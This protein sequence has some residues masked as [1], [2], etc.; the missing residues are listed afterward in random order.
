M[1]PISRRQAL[2]L[3]LVGAASVA[4]GANGLAR[5][6]SADS[7][8]LA[9]TGS[10]RWREPPEL[11]SSGG[12]LEVNLEVALTRLDL[13]G[14]DAHVLTYSGELPGATWRVS[15]GDRI[16]VRLVNRLDAPTNLHFHGLHVSPEGNGDNPFLSIEPGQAF[17]YE[18]R[19]PEDHPPGTY[20]YHPHLHG[21][22][23]DQLFGGLYGAV[24]V[25]DDVPVARERVLVVSDISLQQDGT[26]RPVTVPEQ[27]AGRE[28]EL[29]LVNGQVEPHLSIRAGQTERWRVINACSSRFL[30]LAPEGLGVRAL[31]VDAGRY[32]EPFDVERLLLAP[33]NRADLLVTATAGAGRLGTVGYDRGGPMMMRAGPGD[34]SGPVLLATVAATADDAEPDRLT[35]PPVRQPDLRDR[36]PDRQ[37]VLEFSMGMRMARMTFGFD[38]REFD[39]DRT[40][41][42]VRAGSLEE[43]VIR[44]PTP[45][46]HPFHLHVWPMQVVDHSGTGPR[47]PMWRDVVN[48]PARGEVTVRI[49]FADIGGRTVYHC[50]I[51]DHEDA[52]MMGVVEVR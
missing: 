51:L 48:V 45:M 18:I 47:E 16:A 41:Q 19:L 28:G 20:W 36:R 37:R 43:W 12:R 49:D 50:H 14:T 10:P 27:M 1:E 24:V 11:R 26:V 52:G 40:D 39:P 32:P 34:L 29:V 2:Q 46:D 38:G 30:N 31:A 22:V 9:S 7:P 23:A 13:A 3:G 21:L 17:D 4:V 6:L 35:V 5:S 8:V 25:A 42:Q 15:P 44:N 33:G